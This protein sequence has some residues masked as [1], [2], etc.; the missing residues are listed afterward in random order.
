[1]HRGALAALA[2]TL[3]CLAPAAHAQSTAVSV[4]SVSEFESAVDALRTSGGTIRLQ[5]RAY[6]ELVIPARSARPLRIVGTNGTQVER[7]VLDHTQHVSLEGL[8]VSPRTQDALLD[9]RGSEHVVLSNLLVTAQGTPYS[10]QLRLP[11]SRYVTIRRS[12]FTHCGDRSPDWSN[13][14]L[15]WRWSSYITIEDSWFHDCYGCDFIH[16]RF[17]WNLT[18]RRNRFERALF[19]R[20]DRV[21]CGHNDLIELFRGTGLRVEGNHFGVYRLGGAQLYITNATDHVTIVNNV[22]VGTDPRVRGYTSR[23]ALVI[24][25]KESPRVPRYVR[26]LNN[27]IL[28][29]A[30]RKDGY[31]GS[32][33]LS[34]RYGGMKRARRPIIANNVIALLRSSWPVCSAAQGS[35]SNVIVHGEGCSSSDLVGDPALDRR[36]QPTSASTLLIDTANPRFAPRQDITGRRRGSAPDI[37]AFE[38]RG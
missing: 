22:F 4:G 21:R 36:G 13:C 37:G 9:V 16:G 14:L 18:I 28:T 33:R 26:V 10:A 35:I 6:G 25:S 34:S 19:C 12:T 5:P 24:G 1:M 29:G 7:M 20:F 32:I 31:E 11:D 17:G 30:T 3:V 8:R 38:Y 23:V 27:T 15:L 2:V